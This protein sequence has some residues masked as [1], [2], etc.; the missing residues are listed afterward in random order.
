MLQA[1]QML[2]ASNQGGNQVSPNSTI[3][4]LKAE[5]EKLT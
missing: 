4:Q 1:L 3:L 2:Q 5:I